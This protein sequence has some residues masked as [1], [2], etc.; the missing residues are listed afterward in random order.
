MGMADDLIMMIVPSPTILH[1]K[2]KSAT[3]APSNERVNHVNAI[4][5]SC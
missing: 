4:A 3:V 1:I 5:C 2:E